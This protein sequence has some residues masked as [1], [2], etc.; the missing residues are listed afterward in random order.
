MRLHG[1]ALVCACLP[2]SCRADPLE[3]GMD[4]PLATCRPRRWRRVAS[5]A[6]DPARQQCAGS[7]PP[8]RAF[9]SIATPSRRK[10]PNACL[11]ESRAVPFVPSQSGKHKQHYGPRFNFTRRRMNADRFEGLP[12]YARMRSNPACATCVRD[13]A[14][15]DPA[16][17]GSL[18]DG[19]RRL[20]DDGRLRAPLFRR[21]AS[22]ISTSTSTTCSP[23]ARRSSTS[24]ST[25]TRS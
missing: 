25:R 18:P 24:L 7:A 6:F 14:A 11:R 10:R 15:G 20:R 13:D 5:H 12:D 3:S 21:R 23:T 17:S 19:P 9:G 16:G 4:A 2:R 8:S 1:R 22:R